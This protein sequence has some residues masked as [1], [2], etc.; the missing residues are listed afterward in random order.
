MA[1]AKLT[2]KDINLTVNAPVGARVI[3]ISEKVGT[4]I[5]YGCR[6][7][8]CGTCMMQVEEGWNN[9]TEP[10][11]VEHKALK[12]NNAGRHQRLA[13]QAQILGDVTVRPA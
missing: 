13:C 7:G 1:R 5:I 6:E 10:S 4:G 8:D 11:V 3:D 9:L 12:E 2:F